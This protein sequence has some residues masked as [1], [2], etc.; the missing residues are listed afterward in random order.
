MQLAELRHDAVGALRDERP[1]GGLVQ[2]RDLPRQRK[3][4]GRL[5][6]RRKAQLRERDPKLGAP[7]IRARRHD[8]VP[9]RVPALIFVAVVEV[10][11][12]LFHAGRIHRELVRGAFVVIRIDE[13][14]DPVRRRLRVPA[15]QEAGDLGWLRIV[16]KDRDVEMLG[17]VGHARLGREARRRALFRLALH[18]PINPR[19]PQPH[20]VGEFAVELERRG[21]PHGHGFDNRCRTDG[22]RGSG[23]DRRR[24]AGPFRLC[25][26]TSVQ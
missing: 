18:E 2:A 23:G 14:G 15:R 13:D 6:R 11:L 21:F 9:D 12:V 25:K 5:R 26:R 20:F 19:C 4:E 24:I 8:H 3:A 22:R 10:V 1:G 16:R 7:A 17:V